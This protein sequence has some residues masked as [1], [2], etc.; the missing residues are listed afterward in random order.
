MDEKSA[1]SLFLRGTHTLPQHQT[2]AARLRSSRAVCTLQRAR[3]RATQCVLGT[4]TEEKRE[5]QL[6]R[7]PRQIP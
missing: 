1:T 3:A 6:A 2:D 7:A 4:P 5:R